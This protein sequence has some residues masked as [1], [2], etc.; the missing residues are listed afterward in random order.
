ML[1]WENVFG[2]WVGWN[3]RDRAMLRA[4]TVLQRRHADLLATGEWTPLAAHG[5]G[6]PPT[7]VASRWTD[8]ETTL[9]AVANTGAEP[10]AGELIG[11][12]VE[13]AVPAG[14]IAAIRDGE[15]VM[16]AP[17]DESAAFPARPPDRVPAPIA[18]AAEVPSGLVEA[19]APP[20]SIRSVF[21]R[22]ETGIYD[23]APYVEEWKPLPPRLH[24][25]VEV[26]RE[27]VAA[28]RYAIGVREVTN[29]ELAREGQSDAPATG[30]D[31][32]EAREYARSVG[33]RL[34]TEDEWQLAAEAGLLERA[35]PLV[36]N[37]TE[38]EHTDGRTPFAILKGGS[39]WLAEGSD[40][41]VDG[42]PREARYSLKLLLP[43][44]GLGRSTRIGFRLAVDL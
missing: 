30:F 22:R 3:D 26:T 20:P 13:V 31:L 29:G 40:W 16:A 18:L 4:M 14:G 43:G 8:G 27:P 11:A 21:R 15:Q 28:A 6:S 34:P 17:S 37:W 23:E 9:W 1:V 36:W 41:Y 38:S 12:A 25:F 35:E 10:F 19:P 24:D 5:G 44:G 33:A 42:G 7:V 2:S 32:A 39:A